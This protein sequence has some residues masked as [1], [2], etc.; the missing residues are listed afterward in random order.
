[1]AADSAQK[2]GHRKM[3][4]KGVSRHVA[5]RRF[6][7]LLV[8]IIN[9]SPRPGKR[10][11]KS[12]KKNFRPVN[13]SMTLNEKNYWWELLSDRLTHQPAM[14][15]AAALQAGRKV[16]VFP[17]LAANIIPGGRFYL[18]TGLR[19]LPMVRCPCRQPV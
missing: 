11:K 6:V 16:C 1:M 5:A 4:A 12:A 18:K 7:F 2:T 13:K 3:P 15:I 10:R 14:A 17:L 9:E 8:R 19:R